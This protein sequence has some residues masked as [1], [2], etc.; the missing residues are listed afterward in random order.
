MKLSYVLMNRSGKAR[1]IPPGEAWQWIH[2]LEEEAQLVPM[3]VQLKKK[4]RD[5][6]L[7]LANLRVECPG[8][9][10]ARAK[11]TRFSY[12]G[13]IIFDQTIRPHRVIHQNEDFIDCDPKA[14]SETS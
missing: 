8:A 2:H 7:T 6:R 11:A 1:K 10:T 12:K 5:N 13:P 9:A 14:Q 4:I 3:F